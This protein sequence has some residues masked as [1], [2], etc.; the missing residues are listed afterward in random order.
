MAVN[1]LGFVQVSDFGNPRMLNGG[2]REVISGG[3]FVGVSGTTG[4]VTSG[5]SSFAANDVAFYICDDAECIVGIAMQNVDSG[6]QLAVA[7]DVVALVRCA[8]SVF[9]GR[10]VKAVASAHAVE[11]LGSRIVPANAEDASIAG[12]IAGRAYTAGASGGY[13]LVHIKP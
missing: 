13:A 9:A 3:Y 1:D 2:A 10:L 8:G 5:L 12:D 4:V 7:T 6:A 11:N